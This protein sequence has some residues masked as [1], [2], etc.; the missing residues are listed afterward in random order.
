VFGHAWFPALGRRFSKLLLEV[1]DRHRDAAH[2]RRG[3]AV[4]FA[5][6][7]IFDVVRVATATGIGIGIGIGE[8]LTLERSDVN[9]NQGALLRVGG[10]GLA[11][12][13]RQ[14]FGKTVLL[15]PS[16]PAIHNVFSLKSNLDER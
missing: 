4:A 6:R 13:R 3:D 10:I 5:E 1:W 15:A 9:W 12:A 7:D 2:R 8:A 14:G 11:I 16:E